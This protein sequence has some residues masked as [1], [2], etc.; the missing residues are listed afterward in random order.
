MGRISTSDRVKERIKEWLKRLLAY[1]NDDLGLTDA[2]DKYFQDKVSVNYDNFRT[3][4]VRSEL[5]PLVKLLFPQ[6]PKK[7]LPQ[8]KETFRHDLRVLKSLG[9]LE[10]NRDKR[11]GSSYWHFTIKLWHKSTEVNLEK[12]EQKWDE[13]K[14]I[15]PK[16]LVD[17]PV[18]P[19]T[20]TSDITKIVP[21]RL[22]SAQHNLPTRQHGTLIGRKQEITK[23]LELLSHH[24]N[25]TNLITIE[26][27]GGVGKSALALEVAHRCL[28]ASQNPELFPEIPSFE[29]IIFISAQ[30]Q[31]FMGSSFPR[32][33]RSERNLGDIFRVINQTLNHF[34]RL[35]PT[36]EAQ[37]DAIIDSLSRQSC[38]LTIDNLETLEQQDFVLGFLQ[39]IPP[40][41][42]VV[43]TS[44]VKTGLGTIIGLDCLN[45]EESLE[46]IEHQAQQKG[47]QLSHSDIQSIYPKT[48]GLPLS[49]VYTIGQIAV[50]GMV[51]D[52]IPTGFDRSNQ[53]LAYYCFE[54]SFRQFRGQPAAQLLTAIALFPQPAS[55]ESLAYVALNTTEVTTTKLGLNQLFR[56]SLLEI[57]QERYTIHS[58]T[59]QY[60][61]ADYQDSSSNI[62]DIQNR[63]VGWY[64][65]LTQPCLALDWQEWQDY[66][67][68][69]ADWMNLRTVVEWCR[70]QG[71]FADF[72]DFWQRLKGYTLFGG[73]WLERLDWLDWLIATA[74][75]R[76]EPATVAEGMYHKSRT[77]AHLNETD[78]N[79]EAIALGKQ[80]W[81]L[82]DSQNWQFQFDI[83]IY[84]ATLHSR[85]QEFGL[86]QDW[87]ER[88][89][90]LLQPPVEE[91]A[92][93]RRWIQTRYC[94]AEIHWRTQNHAPAKDL[95]LEALAKAKEINWQLMIS[96]IQGWMA[97]LALA[98]RDWQQ[99]ERLLKLV[100][101]AA[102]RHHDYR[103][104]AYCQRYFA[105]LE[106]QRQRASL[107]CNWAESAQISFE[108][109]RMTQEAAEMRTLWENRN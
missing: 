11:Q 34:D 93:I 53:D 18:L 20:L 6:D 39:E 48:A 103:S 79:G 62:S 28:Q 92:Y 107:A 29:A 42:K 22:I 73:H 81:Q 108:R 50:G 63:W 106:K 2:E 75:Q 10:D 12:F 99:A 14:G 21:Q 88:S 66:S 77:L 68:I 98:D 78:P 97:T 24:H 72:R 9:I 102:E 16:K 49:I 105:L 30:S 84:L 60:I 89:Q 65:K 1:V 31:C 82:S 54:D 26:G 91:E 70:E 57:Q 45:A 5:E 90:T 58:L 55:L 17:R 96:Y 38:L 44:R 47:I 76:Q 32:R 61:R 41:V 19:T 52:T 59:R 109:L 7:D 56:R 95:Y 37:L 40:N 85:K 23:L 80:A 101:E 15:D 8:L 86:A 83:A 33:L 36:L 3:L 46:L 71:R 104:L 69:D 43:L 51:P 87:L 25:N 35:P 13:S 100:L 27:L 67:F 64:L 74:Q 94:K 4:I